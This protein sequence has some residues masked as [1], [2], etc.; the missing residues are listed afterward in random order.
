[1]TLNIHPHHYLN[2]HLSPCECLSIL[3][4]VG[5]VKQ[6]TWELVQIFRT[7]LGRLTQADVDAIVEHAVF[8]PDHAVAESPKESH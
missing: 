7:R 8:K 6:E 1:M 3:E 4:R 5:V 2:P